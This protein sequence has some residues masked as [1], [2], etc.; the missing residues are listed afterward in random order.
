MF[1]VSAAHAGICSV[2]RAS[3]YCQRD[4]AL[5]MLS[6]ERPPAAPLA[7]EQPGVE[8]GKRPTSREP[9]A[10]IGQ[11]GH[12]DRSDAHGNERRGRTQPLSTAQS[13]GLM[14]RGAVAAAVMRN[15]RAAW[16]DQLRNEILAVNPDLPKD[17]VERCVEE[18]VRGVRSAAGRA[19]QESQRRERI[20]A[21]RVL[22]RHAEL[23]V[24]AQAL[25]DA[26]KAAGEVNV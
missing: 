3:G 1:V 7:E 22:D 8:I 2:S 26:L 21:Q 14:D 4:H 9:S 6:T 16:R 18:R 5:F 23:T 15:A 20:A 11:E 17:E 10:R 19:S 12:R 13:G 24:M 25:L